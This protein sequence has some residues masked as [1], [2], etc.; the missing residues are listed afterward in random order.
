MIVYWSK[1][2]ARL[3][4]KR[5]FSSHSFSEGCRLLPVTNTPIDELIHNF[6]ATIIPVHNLRWY[7]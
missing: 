5:L 6:P 1:R 2:L 7:S 3:S 4:L